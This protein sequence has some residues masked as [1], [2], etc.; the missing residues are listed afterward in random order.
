MGTDYT[1]KRSIPG[2]IASDSPAKVRKVLG[3][4]PG[5]VQNHST[6]QLLDPKTATG[7]QAPE[8]AE[9]LELNAK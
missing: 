1:G 5:H 7:D 2:P 4:A 9:A 8:D 6:Q 3:S